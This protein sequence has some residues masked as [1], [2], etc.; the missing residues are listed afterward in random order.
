MTVAGGALRR[1]GGGVGE[2]KRMWTAPAPSRPRPRAPGARRARAGRRAPRLPHAA[3]R[4][5]QPAARGDR[6]VRLGRLQRDRAV[7]PATAPTRAASRF[8]KRLDRRDHVAADARDRGHVA[9]AR[10]CS[11]TRSTPAAVRSP[12]RFTSSAEVP[13]SGI[14]A[15]NAIGSRP[16]SAQP[17]RSARGAR[18]PR[19][20]SGRRCCTR[21]PSGRP[22][23]A[24]RGLALPPR[25]SG[26][27]RLLDR[28]GLRVAA[29]RACSS[30]RSKSNGSSC[31][32]RCTIS[33]CSASGRSGP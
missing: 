24:P 31:Q 27:V 3:A 11:I 1:L 12:S 26:R 2:I 29:A 10:C 22:S 21:P 16:A 9:C 18:A 25:I 20:A 23:A 6:D 7:R 33:I 28:L 8:E 17:R 5:R 32:E 30:G 19:R 14:I 15:E 4:D 13:S